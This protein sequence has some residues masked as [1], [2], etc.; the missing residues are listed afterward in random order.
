M[1]IFSDGR[2]DRVIER[3]PEE[4]PNNSRQTG[5]KKRSSRRLGQISPSYRRQTHTVDVGRR[6]TREPEIETKDVQGI[7]DNMYMQTRL[8]DGN[9]ARTIYLNPMY[10]PATH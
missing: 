10:N 3:V 2:K 9:R 1:G 6:Q 4:L 8:G 7:D 5:W